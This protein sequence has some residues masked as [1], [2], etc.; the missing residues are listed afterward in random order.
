[1]QIQYL[2]GVYTSVSHLGYCK[3]CSFNKTLTCSKLPT[4]FCVK[5]GGFKSSKE[6][7]IFLL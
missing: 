1:M 7:G 5:Y 6:K 4:I 2:N 3:Y